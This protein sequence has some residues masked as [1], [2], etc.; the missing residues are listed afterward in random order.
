M[1]LLVVHR[2]LSN[3]ESWWQCELPSTGLW[4]G[5]GD[6]PLEAYND[7]LRAVKSLDEPNKGHEDYNW[8]QA[9]GLIK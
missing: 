5:E 7:Y 9:R 4:V 2:S 8:C 3:G 1:K 6:S